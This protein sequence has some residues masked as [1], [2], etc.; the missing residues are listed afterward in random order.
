MQS[1]R[2]TFGQKNLFFVLSNKMSKVLLSQSLHILLT[3]QNMQ[4]YRIHP[5]HACP[6]SLPLDLQLREGNK[7]ITTTYM[8]VEW[9]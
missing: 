9:P 7:S 6:R 3:S 1:T 4:L 8:N 5:V 2:K